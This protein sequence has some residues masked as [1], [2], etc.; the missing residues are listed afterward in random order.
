MDITGGVVSLA[1]AMSAQNTSTSHGMI[2]AKKAI[3]QME[4]QGDNLTKMLDSIEVP[5]VDVGQSI[6]IRI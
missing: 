1:N 2:M 4:Q 5:P 3:D 6:D